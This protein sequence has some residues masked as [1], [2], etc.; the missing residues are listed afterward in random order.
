[1]AVINLISENTI[2]HRMLETLSNK[3]ALADGVLDLQGNLNEIKLRSGRQAFLSKLEELMSP[4][5]LKSQTTEFKSV[6]LPADRPLGFAQAAHQRINGALA[7]CEERY[8]QDAA[9][10]VLYVVVARDAAQWREKLTGLHEEFFGSE[11]SDPLPPARLEVID[12][13][14]DEALN[15]LAEPST[16]EETLMAPLALA[17]KD[18]LIALGSFIGDNSLPVVPMI[19]ALEKL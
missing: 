15:R 12:R 7:C 4:L 2:E 18:S 14:T 16:R 19:H 3:K 9:H 17:W 8:P 10:S 1:V 5:N 13:S 6:P 11:K